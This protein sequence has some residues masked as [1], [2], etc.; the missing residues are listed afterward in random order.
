MRLIV[1]QMTLNACKIVMSKLVLK[2][3]DKN[4][5]PNN[6]TVKIN[7]T[8]KN[9][10]RVLETV[11][12]KKVTMISLEELPVTSTNVTTIVRKQRILRKV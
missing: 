6:K 7:A 1:N 10:S 5:N 2:N 4:P 12:R 8:T 3:V 9:A 11:T